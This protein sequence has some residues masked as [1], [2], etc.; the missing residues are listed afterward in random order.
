MDDKNGS[1]IKGK[2]G[3]GDGRVAPEITLNQDNVPRRTSE[4]KDPASLK[5]S[6]ADQNPQSRNNSNEKPAETGANA[7]KSNPV[8]E[9]SKDGTVNQN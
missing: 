1:E 2:P 4:E 7:S 9:D 5:I 3:S 6:E 8:G